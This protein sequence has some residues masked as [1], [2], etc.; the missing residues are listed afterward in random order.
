[1]ELDPYIL[2][3]ES[4]NDKD[5]FLQNHNTVISPKEFNS[6]TLTFSII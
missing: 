2:Q 1:M 3:S 6:D 4:P 5:I